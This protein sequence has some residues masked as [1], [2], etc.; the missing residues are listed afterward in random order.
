MKNTLLS[1]TVLFASFSG[2]GQGYEIK[3][4]LKGWKDTVI[5]LGH[6]YA[7]KNSVKDTVRINSK[8]EFI[9]KGA[10]ELSGGIY[11]V[12][13]PDKKYFEL[14]IDKQQHFSFETDTTDFSKFMKI[15][16]STDNEQFYKYLVLINARSKEAES[17][18]KEMDAAKTDT[19]KANKCKARLVVID[20]EVKQYK[21]DF[22]K[23]NP[24]S[25]LS[26]IFKS[27]QDVEVP[28]APILPNGRKDSTFPYRYYKAHYWDNIDLTDNRMIRTPLFHPKLKFYFEKMMAQVPDSIIRD[29]INLTERTKSAKDLFKYVVYW[30]TYTYESSNVMGMDAVFV[31]MVNKYYKTKQAFW[32]DSTQLKK[33]T[34][35]A[36]ILE[37]LLIGKKAKN[38]I[39]PDS[40]GKTMHALL[41]TKAKY[42]VLYFWEPG[43]GH[44]QKETPKLKAFYDKYKP[45]GVEVFAV[46]IESNLAD[47]KKFIRENKLNWIN[48]GNLY[49]HYYLREM[50]DIYS[51]PVIYLLDEN[52][53]I[54]F[55]RISVEQ[56]EGSIEHLEKE[57][58]K[59]F[60]K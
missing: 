11:L 35:R 42:T 25:F 47:W 10:K 59:K 29:A 56:L 24:T 33:I 51:T 43:C 8:G 27:S 46:D 26:V 13:T 21:L 44:C 14:L 7:D 36:N 40:T 30:V 15:K 60:N 32:V 17:L 3:G 52:K 6:Y 49:H 53:I 12:V 55:K 37:P 54:R 41:D 1:I 9:F 48:V 16:G 50:F 58:L 23:A 5:Y 39:M 2:S 28:P 18:K 45:K 4:K 19:A 38:L 34:D 22:M 57:R 20:K 31:A